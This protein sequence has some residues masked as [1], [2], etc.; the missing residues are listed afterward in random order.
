M[1]FALSYAF[2]A[3]ALLNADATNSDAA[4]VGLQANHILH[5]ELSAFLWGSGY[6]TS[7]D[8]FFVA[9][10]YAALGMSPLTL[11][12]TALTLNTVAAVCIYLALAGVRAVGPTRALVL[13]CFLVFTSSA[14]HS[15]ALYPPRQASLTLALI[16][17]S[18]WIA[19]PARGHWAAL[20]YA[21]A[22][23]ADPYPLVLFPAAF[24]FA[25]CAAHLAPARKTAGIEQAGAF[26]LGI[27]PFILLRMSPRATAAPLSFS[28]SVIPHNAS[29]L[30]NECL[31]W[32]LS[33]KTYYAQHVM[34]YAQWAAPT[35]FTRFAVVAALTLVPLLASSLVLARKTEVPFAVRAAGIAGVIAVGTALAGFVMSVMVMDHFSMRYLAVITLMLPLGIAPVATQLTP[36]RLALVCAPFLVSS[37]VSGWVGYGPFVRG[38]R[39]V[40]LANAADDEALLHSLAEHRVKYAMA[41]YWTAY[42]L[43]LLARERVIVVPKNANEDRYRPYREE[44]QVAP[45]FAYVFDPDRSRE[46]LADVPTYLG[47]EGNVTE[48]AKIGGLTVFFVQRR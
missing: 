6:Q 19:K 36:A 45:T 12:L 25:A 22:I 26:A 11:M 4:I 10:F 3:P 13:G 2:R 23:V 33:I 37:A 17:F 30:W 21:L 48:R 20:I 14:M 46:S 38:A 9:V 5:G 8:A 44:W 7:V 32:A 24:V 43:T 39:A 15:Y 34:D 27:V 31:P 40:V 35:W 16:A 1:L 28:R 42:R 47:S 29:L 18:I 41:D